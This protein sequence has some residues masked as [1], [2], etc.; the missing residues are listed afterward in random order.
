[1]ILKK[2]FVDKGKR[3]YLLHPSTKVSNQRSLTIFSFPF[4][5]STGGRLC[6]MRSTENKLL[7][8]EKTEIS[9]LDYFLSTRNFLQRKVTIARPTM[10][11]FN[12]EIKKKS[13]RIHIKTMSYS[14][15]G[16]GTH[17][18]FLISKRYEC[19]SF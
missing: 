1:M 3:N 9:A 15:N 4:L 12:L 18:Y 10:H 7:H 17:H 6:N 8:I 11:C 16:K 14:Q 5:A 13:I 19:K 2:L